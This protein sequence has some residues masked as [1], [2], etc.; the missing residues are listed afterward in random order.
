M[1]DALL[2]SAVRAHQAGNLAEAARLYGEVLRINPRHFP[3]MYAMGFLH[4]EVGRFE[5]AC[6]IA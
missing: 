4:Y 1:N 2:Q 6:R 5:E 3:A